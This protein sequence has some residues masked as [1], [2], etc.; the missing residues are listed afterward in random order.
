MSGLTPNEWQGLG[1]TL[2]GTPIA[3]IVVAKAVVHGMAG[4]GDLGILLACVVG[5]AVF[6]AVPMAAARLIGRPPSERRQVAHG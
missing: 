1:A 2:V 6:L 3:V 5:A 4:H